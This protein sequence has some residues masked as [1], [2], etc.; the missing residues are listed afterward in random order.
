MGSPFHV[1][2]NGKKCL[3]LFD[4]E[5]ILSYH[6]IIS[7]IC[8]L[9]CF[10]N[11]CDMGA[12]VTK[13]SDGCIHVASVSIYDEI[14]RLTGTSDQNLQAAYNTYVPNSTSVVLCC[15]DAVLVYLKCS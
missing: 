7:K 12:S 15:F 8:I 3:A 14:G 6:S 4:A 1:K 10:A 9:S 5:L 13:R 2:F 11:I